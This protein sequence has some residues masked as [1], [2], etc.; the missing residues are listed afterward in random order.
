MREVKLLKRQVV[1]AGF[2]DV[3]VEDFGVFFDQVKKESELICWDV[4]DLV[5]LETIEFHRSN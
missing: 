2:R 1:V 3:K 4:V 5:T